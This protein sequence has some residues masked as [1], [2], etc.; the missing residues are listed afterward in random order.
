MRSVLHP[1]IPAKTKNIFVPA[2]EA[3][4]SAKTILS[5]PSKPFDRQ[6]SFCPG[7]RSPSIAKNHFFPAAEAFQSPKILFSRPP[8][9]F[10]L[11]NSFCPS[12]QHPPPPTTHFTLASPPLSHR[13][14]P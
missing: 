1:S 2:I 10:F 5:R 13:T 12:R 3:L 9:P 8:K 4:G 6:K 14:P 7:R 11:Q